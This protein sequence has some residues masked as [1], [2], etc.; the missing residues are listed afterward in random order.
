MEVLIHYS[1]NLKLYY[2]GIAIEVILVNFSLVENVS[3]C[4]SATIA[5]VIKRG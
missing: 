1:R 4:D 2:V 5:D 3:H